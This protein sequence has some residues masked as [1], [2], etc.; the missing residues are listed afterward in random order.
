[1]PGPTALSNNLSVIGGGFASAIGGSITAYSLGRNPA[2]NADNGESG[3]NVVLD[4]GHWLLRE[5]IDEAP[6]DCGGLMGATD[7]RRTGYHHTWELVALYDLRFPLDILLRNIEDF[8]ID[9]WLGYADQSDLDQGGEVIDDRFYWSPF[10]KLDSSEK[11]FDAKGEELGQ[12]K[13]TGH[14]TGL[15]FLVPEQGTLDNIA[16]LAGAYQEW[17]NQGGG[18]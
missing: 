13:L 14:A 4:M 9:F 3:S 2:T 12:I 11:L 1:M 17:I 16:T 10:N 18:N 15:V 5:V 8:R 7:S 6:L